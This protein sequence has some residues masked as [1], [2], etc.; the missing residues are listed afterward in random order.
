MNL[1]LIYEML[2]FYYTNIS[3]CFNCLW[4]TAHFFSQISILSWFFLLLLFIHII[5]VTCLDRKALVVWFV[6]VTP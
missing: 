4:F 2:K 6:K 3:T 5:K 1:D